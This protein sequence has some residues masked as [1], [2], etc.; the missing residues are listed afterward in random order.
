MPKMHDN[1]LETDV[2]LV[3]R[4]LTTQFPQWAQLPLIPVVFAGTDNVT[5]RLGDDMMVRFPRIDW[6]VDNAHKEH[7]WLPRL[8]LLLPLA[9]P[10]PL[11][12]GSPGA[13]YPRHWSV[14]EWLAGKNATMDG[15]AAPTRGLLT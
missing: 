12:K 1:E 7:Y 10:V 3:G 11:A 9:I 13:G 4:L 15:I 14:Y 2:S 8:V 6:A 5:C